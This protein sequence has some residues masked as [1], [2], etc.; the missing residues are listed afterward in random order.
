MGYDWEDKRDICYQLY[1]VERKPLDAVVDY[2]KERLTFTPRCVFRTVLRI[3]QNAT[4]LCIID[5]PSLS[6]KRTFQTQ[7]KVGNP[8]RPTNQ[9]PSPIMVQR[10]RTDD[11]SE[12]GL[13]DQ[14]RIYSQGRKGCRTCKTIM[15]A[16]YDAEGDDSH[17]DAGGLPR[18]RKQYN[19]I[20]CQTWHA[21]QKSE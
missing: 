18:H 13:S 9:L 20:A 4:T 15:G 10:F 16:E 8:P 14:N 19:A 1:V 17:F 2:F 12:M 7:F 6:S 11:T 3:E 21:S 5:L